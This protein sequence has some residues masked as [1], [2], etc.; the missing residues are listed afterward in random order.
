MTHD[1]LFH[2]PC[3]CTPQQN[4]TAVACMHSP[5]YLLQIKGFKYARQRLHKHFEHSHC[6]KSHSCLMQKEQKP[7]C[8]IHMH[9]GN[10]SL[11]Q[12]QL[13]ICAKA[14]MT[15]RFQRCQLS[16]VQAQHIHKGATLP[17]QDLQCKSDCAC[18]L[19]LDLTDALL[20]LCWSGFVR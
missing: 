9:I 4:N 18:C 7:L 13:Q 20:V 14:V 11:R 12:K 2:T 16:H 8:I 1:Q 19:D 5:K 3:T 6:F 15:K 10:R 17:T